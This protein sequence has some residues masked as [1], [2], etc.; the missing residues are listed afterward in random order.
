[1]RGLTS[2]FAVPTMTASLLVAVY[3]WNFP[4]DLERQR[5][6]HRILAA[7]EAERQAATGS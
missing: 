4:L 7:R 2:L 1:V 6:L 3:M 5:E